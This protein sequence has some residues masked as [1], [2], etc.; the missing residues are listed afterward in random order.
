MAGKLRL[1]AGV[2]L[3]FETKQ[4]YSVTVNVDDASVGNS[5]DASEAFTLNISNVTEL[6]GI[7]IQKG[8]KQ[9]SFV[10]NVDILFDN[11]AGL[12]DLLSGNR[13][14]LTR[15]DLNGLNP[16]VMTLPTSSVSGN[17]IQLDF[18]AQGIGGNRSSNVGDGYYQIAI[19][20][21]GDGSF[22]SIKHFFRLYGDVTGDGI[23]DSRD[24]AQVMSM[25]GTTNVEGDLNGD[26]VVNLAD[27]TAV[28]R[29]VGRKL[30]SGLTWD[31]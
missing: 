29:A 30:K 16:T 5:P 27:T 11:D 18:G 25:S 6:A 24:K 1:K 2:A 21:D 3:D 26:G 28:S 17:Q 20:M 19:D 7:D 12:A 15:M 22:E 13:V 23:V 31:D 8:H 14:K 10:R 9:R 4:S